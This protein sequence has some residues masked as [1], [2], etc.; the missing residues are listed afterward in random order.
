MNNN[1]KNKLLIFWRGWGY[2]IVVALIIAMSFRSAIAEFNDVPTGSMKP[3]ILEGDRLFVNKL[4]YDL[5][6]PFTTYHITCWGHPER[7]DIV[8]FFSP[9]DGKRLVKRVIGLPGDTIAM[10][11]NQLFIN[12]KAV[13]Y[14][15]PDQE[16]ISHL[17]PDQRSDHIFFSENIFGKKHSLMITPGRPSLNTFGPL[18][19]PEGQ[20]FMMGDNRDNSADSR[21]FGFVDRNLI[22]GRAIGIFISLKRDEHYLPRWHRFFQGLS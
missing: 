9:E 5:K 21:F 8:V 14:E 20:Y 7:G 22:V 17:P 10:S 3:T 13:T 19:I 2:S 15:S 12:G 18:L 16:T 4:A 11:A 6:V 1:L